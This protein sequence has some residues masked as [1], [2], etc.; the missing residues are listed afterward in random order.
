MIKI[1]WPL[2]SL[3]VAAAMFGSQSADA[4]APDIDA[5]A[6]LV[7]NADDGKILYSSE[8]NSRLAIASLTKLMT[9][10]LVL[11]Q[12]PLEE[13]I[14]AASYKPQPA[15]S[16]I[17][18]RARESMTVEDLLYALLLAS[19]NDAA[20]TFAQRLAGSTSSFVKEMNKKARKMGLKNTRFANPV[21]LDDK[22]NFSSAKDLAKLTRK[23]LKVKRFRQIVRSPEKTIKSGDRQRRLVNRNRLVAQHKFIT[24]V[25]TGRTAASGYS[26]IG[27]GTKKGVDL[28]TV[29]LG[30]GSEESR[31]A[32]TLELFKYG[33]DRYKTV[34]AVQRG[35]RYGDVD[36]RF[37]GTEVA[38]EA[39]RSISV[40][41]RRGL[42]VRVVSDYQKEVTKTDR[43]ESLGT[44]TVVVGGKKAASTDLVA[45]RSVGSAGLFRKGVYYL[46]KPLGLIIL[47]VLLVGGGVAYRRIR[48]RK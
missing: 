36:V 29:L 21:G 35:R 27:S 48:L 43:G 13:R 39:D 8:P 47:L 22:D 19:A 15:E 18:L 42:K 44:V 33:F 23:L 20:A 2:L 28:V 17:D 26:L 3:F 6:A 9:A 37:R 45:S 1:K 38:L 16:K 41:V 40:P 25:K 12:V 34:K 4:R 7:I 24:G 5:R 31:D 46:A 10:L 32:G 14:T 30:A 11:E